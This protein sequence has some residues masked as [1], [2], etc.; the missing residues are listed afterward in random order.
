MYFIL[1][2]F[3]LPLFFCKY[4]LSVDNIY[5]IDKEKNFSLIF[6]LKR[7]K[8]SKK[9]IANNIFNIII[10]SENQNEKNR[11]INFVCDFI[12]LSLYNPHIKCFLKENYPI[13]LK[14][15]FYFRQE[16]F[17]KSFIIKTKNEILYFTLEIL[18]EIFYMG[19][20]KCFRTKKN[21]IN[22]NY[23]ISYV[24]IPISMSLNNDYIYPTIVAITSILEN[25]YSYTKYDFYILFTPNLLLENINKLK[26]FEKKYQNKCSINLFNMTNFK[27]ENA[28]LSGHI[29]TIAAYYRLILPDLLPN[30]NKIIYLDSDTLTFDDL[31][32][33]YDINM[34]N[35]YYKGF[36]DI[37][38]RFNLNIEN[39]ICSGVLLINLE[40]L[41]KDNIINK[42]YKYMIKNNQ[43]LYS[44]DQSL[45]NDVCSKKIGI[46][47]AK[48]GIPNISNLNS[49][50]YLT[51]K[52][53]KKKKKY[54]YS[55]KELKNAYFHPSIL[56]CIGK[57][58]KKNN[59]SRK[60]WLEFVEKSIFNYE[61]KKKYNL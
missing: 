32:E 31:K 35:F 46:L 26:H 55:K 57:P 5:T 44:H 10:N 14:G 51:K 11:K 59:Y 16:F 61:I 43:N 41:R 15:P 17:K 25:A 23:K 30:I 39:Y 42:M 50:Y 40:N 4:I 54:R 45:I 18:E 8:I 20:I 33:M 12:Y 37:N 22:F 7:L 6:N 1:L 34:E 28:R 49:L 48:F 2:I 60:L 52:A 21:K 53:Y 3:L 47:P 13:N 24:L 36:L 56:H 9:F 19:M 58:W 27:F 38:L 29:Q